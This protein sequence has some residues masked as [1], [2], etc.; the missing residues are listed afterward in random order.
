[1]RR[2]GPPQ[3]HSSAG[4][5][6]S[7]IAPAVPAAPRMM[8]LLSNPQQD[9]GNMHTVGKPQKEIGNKQHDHIPPQ[10]GT[11]EDVP[12]TKTGFLEQAPR[13]CL[14]SSVCRGS[15]MC[16]SINT[17]MAST[18]VMTS[19]H[20]MPFRPMSEQGHP[21]TAPPPPVS[22]DKGHHPIALPC[23]SLGTMV[24]MAAE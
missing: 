14:P 17:P 22:L 24:V 10:A 16:T 4:S 13:L 20:R 1:M 23:C 9:H 6:S 5:L 12:E 18:N 15:G 2:R 7:E 19:I 11:L 21:P 3:A 8:L